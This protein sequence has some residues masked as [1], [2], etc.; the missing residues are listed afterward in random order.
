MEVKSSKAFSFEVVNLSQSIERSSLY[1]E[2]IQLC[3]EMPI[4]LNTHVDP[5]PIVR[6]LKK[7]Q[8]AIFDSNFHRSRSSIH[9]ILDEL[10]ESVHWSDDDLAGSNLVDDI[11]VQRLGRLS[12]SFSYT[13]T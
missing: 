3:Q 10:L 12:A 6:N 11:F 8:T 2:G 1:N 7:L 13:T 5:M 9:G 4:A